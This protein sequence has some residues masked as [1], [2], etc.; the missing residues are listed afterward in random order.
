MTLQES[1]QDTGI[2][3]L[4]GV[5]PE[6][7]DSWA[8]EAPLKLVAWALESMR[9]TGKS[10]AIREKLEGHFV[11]DPDWKVWWG[12][13]LL[14][15]KESSQFYVGSNTSIRLR[16]KVA[17]IPTESW[18][19]LRRPTKA[20]KKKAPTVAD[21]R[22]WFLNTTG[23]PAP[24]RFPTKAAIRAFAKMS[25]SDTGRAL[26]RTMEAAGQVLEPGPEKISTQAARAWM[27]AVFRAWLR[28]RDVSEPDSV[29]LRA[30]GVGELL[31]RLVIVAGGESGPLELLHSAGGL[32][33]Q[34]D[35]GQ[36]E[37]TSGMWQVFQD[38]VGNAWDLLKPPSLQ[39]RASL[40][41]ELVPAAFRAAAP[42]RQFSDLEL[43]LNGL[44]PD[45]QGRLF[46]DLMVRS[47]AGEAPEEKVLNYLATSRH[48]G[49]VQDP[50]HNCR[51]LDLLAM[52]SHLLNDGP[53]GVAEEAAQQ[54]AE[55][56]ADS[57]H[58]SNGPVSSALFA[59]FR[60]QMVDLN[61]KQRNE[62][63]SQSLSHERQLAERREEQERLNL[64]VQRLRNQIVAGR[65]AS[66]MDI[67]QDIL[68]VI[69]ETVQSFRQRKEN[70]E[71]LVRHV[72]ARLVLAL[73][74]G[75]AEEFGTI[76]ETVS[77]DPTQHEA[78]TEIPI[79]SPVRVAARGAV[80]HGKATGDRVLIKARVE[81]Q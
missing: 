59:A 67:L 44:P 17:D 56:L 70:P 58:Q 51:R 14:R 78:A 34:T 53:G 72:E 45:E 4:E 40:A 28:F 19:S 49:S 79:R 8:S 74:V 54:V 69:S 43:V 18:D 65:E 31:A 62:L 37:F 32:L 61:V 81:I 25:A 23:D 60:Q 50:A 27:E 15:L 11:R 9:R 22:K 10:K 68:K 29:D 33:G 48:A 55:A 24:G 73:R 42:A 30:R 7:L 47:A 35:P 76:G 75:G 66:R 2:E 52:A 5:E 46:R 38:S 80:M 77:Y 41:R 57:A 39:D 64:E 63:E 21:W 16:A 6:P 13:V 12:R 36:R 71:E 1:Q 26:E 20:P 3:S